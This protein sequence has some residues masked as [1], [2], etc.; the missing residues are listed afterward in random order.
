MALE[1]LLLSAFGI[2]V[3]L[4]IVDLGQSLRVHYLVWR[5][6]RVAASILCGDVILPP[7]FLPLPRPPRCRTK[8]AT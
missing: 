5:I 4:I 2:R 7:R 1:S 6:V 8:P 3:Y